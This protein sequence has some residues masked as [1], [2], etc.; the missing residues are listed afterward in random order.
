MLAGRTVGT[1]FK[2]SSDFH[3]KEDLNYGTSGDYPD[4]PSRHIRG[5]SPH[6]SNKGFPHETLMQMKHVGNTSASDSPGV[7]LRQ[8]DLA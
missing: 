1:P 2:H 6:Q 3:Q 5:K 7:T 4:A 8:R